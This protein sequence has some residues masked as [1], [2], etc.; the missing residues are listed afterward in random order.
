MLNADA[1]T[2]N[3]AAL[4]RKCGL[5]RAFLALRPAKAFLASKDADTWPVLSVYTRCSF[6]HTNME[7]PDLSCLVQ[8]RAQGN[9]SAM[10]IDEGHC[11]CKTKARP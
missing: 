2:V 11:E 7:G 1:Y 8:R 3:G 6:K 10:D 5:C 9:A 4:P